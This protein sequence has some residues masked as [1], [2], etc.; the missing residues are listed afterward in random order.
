VVGG[1]GAVMV[2][3][4]GGGHGHSHQFSKYQNEKEKVFCLDFVAILNAH[5]FYVPLMLYV[6]GVFGWG[7][8]LWVILL[9]V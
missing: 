4:E 9:C 3:G 5:G 2:V 1:E 7:M 6:G 8:Y